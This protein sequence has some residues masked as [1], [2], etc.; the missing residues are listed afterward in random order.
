MAARLRETK[1]PRDAGPFCQ[2]VVVQSRAFV[3]L[4][5]GR[6][7]RIPDRQRQNHPE[8]KRHD[9]P[10][11]CPAWVWSG[12]ERASETIV[13][14]RCGTAQ[15]QSDDVRGENDGRAFSIAAHTLDPLS[16]DSRGRSSVVE[17]QLP[18]L[19]VVGSIPIARSS[20]F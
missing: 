11:V 6:R 16:F 20:F 5:R 14:V 3:A 10:R 17:R 2:S 7:K 18:K 19:N 15:R 8:Q 9:A 12:G 4:A 1:K 13:P